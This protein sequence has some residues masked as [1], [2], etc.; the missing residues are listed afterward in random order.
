MREGEDA[1]DEQIDLRLIH[2]RPTIWNGRLRGDRTAARPTLSV[3][4]VAQCTDFV[5]HDG[6]VALEKRGASGAI[7]FGRAPP[8]ARDETSKGS[9]ADAATKPEVACFDK[10]EESF[11]EGIFLRPREIGPQVSLHVEAQLLELTKVLLLPEPPS[12]CRQDSP[13]SPR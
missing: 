6:R 12:H 10:V 4:S 2:P 1:R 9:A 11:D 3:P 5:S 8:V 13:A 7:V